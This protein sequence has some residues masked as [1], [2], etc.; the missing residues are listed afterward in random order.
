MWQ[1][2]R[3]RIKSNAS[4]IKQNGG[5]RHIHGRR[6]TDRPGARSPQRI[7][8]LH[9]LR[10]PTERG[11]VEVAHLRTEQPQRIGER[12]TC[13]AA[14]VW[15][16]RCTEGHVA[17]NREAQLQDGLVPIFPAKSAG[18]HSSDNNNTNR[19]HA[20]ASPD[21]NAMNVEHATPPNR[22]CE[23]ACIQVQTLD[24]VCTKLLA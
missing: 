14:H 13:P 11:H 15:H 7:Q 19:A 12:Q 3:L 18:P 2:R 22:P 16:A 21:S 17:E 1:L 6:A 24:D 8:A 10:L 9:C 5:T 4:V 23:S 20:G